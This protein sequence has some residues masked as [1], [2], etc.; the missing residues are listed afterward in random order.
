MIDLFNSS[1]SLV[2]S[3]VIGWTVM[4]K[5]V[6]DGVIVKIGL[7]CLSIGFLA[8]WMI[9]LQSGYKNSDALEVVHCLIYTGMA[10]CIGGYKWRTHDGGRGRRMND[11]ISI[12]WAEK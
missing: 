11:W 8:A 3:L 7:I 1:I 5:H 12:E 6:K 9:T 2:L 10:V 4:S